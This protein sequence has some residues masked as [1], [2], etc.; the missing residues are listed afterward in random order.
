MRQLRGER[1]MLKPVQADS[2]TEESMTLEHIDLYYRPWWAFEFHWRSKDKRA[3]SRSTRSL[4]T[5]ARAKRLSGRSSASSHATPCSISERTPS[6][7]SCPAAG[8]P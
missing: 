3:S 5:C 1:Q 7:C 2:I 6:A 4:V 8:S